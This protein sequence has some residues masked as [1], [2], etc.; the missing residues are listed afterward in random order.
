[1]EGNVEKTKY[2]F[3]SNEQNTGHNH[4]IKVSFYCGDIQVF[5]MKLKDLNCIHKEIKDTLNCRMSAT[6]RY[7]ILV[8]SYAVRK[9]KDNNVQGLAGDCSCIGV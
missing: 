1:M 6:V 8:L 4:D 5:G 9:C 2:M 3:M 7:G